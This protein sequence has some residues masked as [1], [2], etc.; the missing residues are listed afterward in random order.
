MLRIVLNIVASGELWNYHFRYTFCWPNAVQLFREIGP[1]IKCRATPLNHAVVLCPKVSSHKQI[2]STLVVLIQRA[3]NSHILE[4]FGGN[5][6]VFYCTRGHLRG[7][8]AYP[9]LNGTTFFNFFFFL[10]FRF[11]KNFLFERYAYLE[12]FNIVSWPHYQVCLSIHVS[13]RFLF[14]FLSLLIDLHVVITRVLLY[15]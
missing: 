13:T 14:F 3:N 12:Y 7:L 5:E 4:V 10:I 15:F 1:W 11:F 8:L 9:F 6:C 2:K